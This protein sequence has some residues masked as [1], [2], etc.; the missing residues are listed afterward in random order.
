[1]SE[2]LSRLIMLFLVLDLALAGTV[3]ADLVGWWKLDDGSGTIAHDSTQNGNHGTL[4]GNPQW[5][6]GYVGGALRLDGTDGYVALPIGSMMSSLTNSTLALW[7][8][9]SGQGGAWQ[10]ILD[11]GT[12][13]ANYIYVCPQDGGGALH[14]ALTANTGTWT[15]IV[16][17]T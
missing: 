5:V 1:M 10:R 9:F 8:N 4:L 17:P 7:V 13:T 3:C 11:F 16:A 14:V 6:A 15:D 2:R 12:S